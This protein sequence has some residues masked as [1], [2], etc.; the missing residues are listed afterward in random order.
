MKTKTLSLIVLLGLTSTAIVGAATPAGAK[1]DA[2]VTTQAGQM[3]D[4]EKKVI[5]VT[6]QTVAKQAAK[7]KEQKTSVT[8]DLPGTINMAIANNYDVKVA[9]H[10]Y[11]AAAA[12]VS[13]SAAAKNPTV[14]YSYSGTRTSAGYSG[15]QKSD[16]IGNSFAQGLT[17][18]VPIYTG[19]SA[20]GAIEKARY[21]REIAGATLWKTE[22]A[23]KLSAA[24]GYF[25]ILQAQN[26]AVIATQSVSDLQ[27]H[28]DNVNAQ[29]NVGIVA[30]SDVLASQVSLANAKTTQITAYNDVDLAK[31]NLSNILGIPVN[32][33]IVIADKEFHY[34][35]YAIT[36]EQAQAYALLHRAELVESTLAVEVAKQNIRIAEAGYKPTV[37]ATATKG[38]GGSD[39]ST[40]DSRSWTLG[41]SLTWSLWDGGAT[42]NSIKVAKATLAEAEAT[43]SQTI[44]A[45]LLSVRQA[46]LNLKVAGATIKSTKVAV[47]QGEENFRIASLRYQAG[48][49]TNLDV[50]DAELNLAQ[51]RYNY[52]NAL[53]SYNTYV[54]T[55]EQTI[56]APINSNI[57]SGLLT[58]T[59]DEATMELQT[60][61]NNSK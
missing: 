53:Y 58:A 51:A 13:V 27:S 45:V 35:P 47:D 23:T 56:G 6:Q 10:A 31:A 61:I 41:G 22:E 2:S 19:G 15:N 43:N 21:N 17:L 52:I 25:A 29:Y 44:N 57:G 39:A 7:D 32:T 33:N 37:K 36:L 8:L 3:S 11:D 24:T 16:T 49:G 4:F 40:S 38:W 48:V 14:G 46:Y 30:K 55:L 28:L 18:G 26:K 42:T 54:A 34:T 9:A 12:S 59:S 20:E 50:L 5:A 1:V 60:L